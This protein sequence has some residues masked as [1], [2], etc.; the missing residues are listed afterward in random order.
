MKSGFNKESIKK[1]NICC[2]WVDDML[3]IFTWRTAFG[4]TISTP[5]IDRLLLGG[6]RFENAYATIP[7]CTPCRS[8][9]AT[10]LSPFR[11]GMV[12]TSLGWRKIMRPEK[13]WAYDLRSNGFYCFTTGKVDGAYRPMPESFKRVLF[14][15]E[16]Q[17]RDRKRQWKK[18]HDYVK[19]GPG[20]TGVNYPDDDGSQDH[21]FY[22]YEVAQNAIDFLYRANPDTR[23]FIRLGFKHP[24]FDLAC[25]NRFYDLYDPRKIKW[26]DSAAP[27]DF[28]GPPPGMAVYEAAYIA[29][30]RLTPENAGA[31]NWQEA[32]RAYFA[33]VSHVDY[34]IG[35]FL[36]ALEQSPLAEN[37]T[38][39]FLSDNGFNLGT[40]DSF[41]KM[42]QWD[43][44][45]HIPFG[46]W[47]P[48]MTEPKTVSL[49]ISLHNYSKTIFDLAGLPYR[50]DWVSGQS[51]LPL[52]DD[53]FGN[54]DRSKSPITAVYGTL[55]VRPSVSGL[56]HFR[57][58]RYPNGEENVYNVTTDPGE[59]DNLLESAPDLT[60]LKEL[61]TELIKGALDLGLDIGGIQEKA[62]APAAL[63]A[64]GNDLALRGKKS[65]NDY[66]AY[67][68]AAEKIEEEIDGGTDTLWY[69]GGPDDYVL[70]APKNVEKIRIATVLANHEKD[71]NR[72][73]VIKVVADPNTAL[74][75]I[76]TPN[77]MVD[78]I[79]SDK[80]DI[81]TAGGR[82]RAFL[83]GG[84]GN[85]TIYGGGSN[86]TL[87]GGA[88][89]DYIVSG[90]RGGAIYGGDGNDEIIVTAKQHVRV[91][92][93]LGKNK[94]T[95]GIG[96]STVQLGAGQNY[97]KTAG[98]RVEFEIDYGGIAQ[99]SCWQE[100][101]IYNVSSWPQKPEVFRGSE[102]VDLTLG[103]CRIRIDKVPEDVEIT[104]QMK[105]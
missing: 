79:G 26:P 14:H 58:F 87:Y 95:L 53:S 29:H 98:G 4:E 77:V 73:K 6:V 36:D 10:G 72:K 96:P 91:E 47:N 104:K 89:D 99:I 37:T 3:D 7:I 65:D 83:S 9:L 66:W 42:S 76:S 34:E 90:T 40:H 44:A 25:P 101:D 51:L 92:T 60:P 16:K 81:L 41:H 55:S 63:L 46:I 93:G 54:Y 100:D 82:G 15:E 71:S 57:Y 88:G 49:P 69:L 62:E 13:G 19:R 27:E 8:E 67:G 102:F 18:V 22:D 39:I 56:E 105:Y 32:V 21:N 45:A 103:C 75:F 24:H 64:V 80:D 38:V 97:V 61:R 52:I 68:P 31:S 35:R 2:I 94:V 48:R 84:K 43:S 85:D 23:H 20:L 50:P 5:N 59:T 12:D 11:T 78:V 70:K 30:G 1:D 86:G 33:A 74:D 17:C 28:T